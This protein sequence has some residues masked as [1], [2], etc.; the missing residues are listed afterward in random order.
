MLT[1]HCY[2]QIFEQVGPQ[3]LEQLIA[4]HFPI[5]EAE[6][7]S[8]V[9]AFGDFVRRLLA[10]EADER[11]TAKQALAHPFITEEFYDPAWTPP[12]IPPQRPADGPRWAN[13][14]M[15]STDFL[16]LM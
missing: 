14:A 11:L 13:V 8:T 9:A 1:S 15:P 12:A 16:S 5:A 4:E 10:Y 3:P 7:I 6:E 2:H